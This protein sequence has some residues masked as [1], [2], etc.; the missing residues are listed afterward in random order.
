MT[1]SEPAQVD[2]SFAS[3]MK[4]IRA[5]GFL[6]DKVAEQDGM[7]SSFFTEGG[8]L[9]PSELIELLRSTWEQD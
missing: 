7:A 3:E 8:Q 1:A 5:I 2:G 9:L 4:L 6:K